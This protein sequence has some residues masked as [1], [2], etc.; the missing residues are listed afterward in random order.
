MPEKLQVSD[1]LGVSLKLE[2][3]IGQ[4]C[5]IFKPYVVGYSDLMWSDTP[6]LCGRTLRPY[7]DGH[8]VLIGMDTPS[9]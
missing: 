3:K 9:L 2:L 1:V 6:T 5:P 7:V 8:S 4:G